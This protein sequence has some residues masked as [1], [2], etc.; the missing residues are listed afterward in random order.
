M[1]ESFP[2]L[3]PTPEIHERPELACAV[4]AVG[5][6]PA[7]IAAVR[8]LMEQSEPIEVVVINS[9]GA[10]AARS[11]AEAGLQ[12][13]VIELAERILPGAARNR[14][15][16]ATTAPY[17][18][19][20]AADCVA[21][22][23]WAAARLRAHRAGAAAVASAVTNPFPTSLPAWTSYIALFPRRMPGVPSPDAL[24]YGVSYKR[25]LFDAC[26]LFREEIRGGEDTEFHQRLSAAGVAI[27]WAPE[28]RTA[29]HHPTGL[30]ELLRDQFR[31]GARSAL[32]WKR[33]QGPRPI[34][35]AVNAFQRLP[36]GARLAW[37]AAMRG[38]RKWVTAAV[39]LLPI[40]ATAYA[41]G[42]IAHALL[43]SGKDE[44]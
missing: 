34:Q 9:G 10:G 36:A 29:H 31:R 18:S 28:V 25:H 42:C 43:E 13:A 17:I 27:V 37:R 26:G 19:F 5:N 33:L 11:L 7:L 30:F 12:V 4:L 14:G 20:L 15:I 2:R 16:A 3:S 32:A 38:E 41:A 21:E 39:V 8:S 44:E 1:P 6:P 22:P 35:V 23:G 24:L 40:A